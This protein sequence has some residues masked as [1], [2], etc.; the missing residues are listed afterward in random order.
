MR[1][2]WICELYPE[3]H[4]MS[5]I[6][7][8]RTIS[9]SESASGK[10][11]LHFTLAREETL[12]R[13]AENPANDPKWF[14]CKS[15]N[16]E[17][18]SQTLTFSSDLSAWLTSSSERQFHGTEHDSTEP[19][20]INLNKV[21]NVKCS[22]ALIPLHLAIIVPASL[23]DSWNYSPHFSEWHIHTITWVLAQSTCY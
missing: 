23:I 8:R 1:K 11:W 4:F 14:L 3:V 7:L 10:W 5:G 13:A 9:L 20:V 19:A 16:E 2:P 17:R 6:A 12:G 22:S 15:L 21:W 18:D